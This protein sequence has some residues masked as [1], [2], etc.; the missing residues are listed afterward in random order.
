MKDKHPENKHSISD[1]YSR[2][3]V[4]SQQSSPKGL[5][6][7]RQLPWEKMTIWTL[8]LLLLWTLQEFFSIL[9]FTFV[10][11][12]IANTIVSFFENWSSKR[13]LI[14]AFVYL[15]FLSIILG[16]GTWFGEAVIEMAVPI[17][18]NAGSAIKSLVMESEIDTQNESPSSDLEPSSN[19]PI[20]PRK[21]ET[22]SDKDPSDVKPVLP[23][24]KQEKVSEFQKPEEIPKYVRNVVDKILL[25]SIGPDRTTTF[26]QT[27]YYKTLL[28]EANTLWIEGIPIITGYATLFLQNTFRYTL[29]ILIAL[30]FSFLIVFDIPH[31]RNKLKQFEEG[32]LQEFYKEITPS[33]SNFA[34]VL[35]R[36][37]QAQAMIAIC[38]TIF[39]WGALYFLEIPNRALLT[40][41]VLVFSFVPV[42]GVIIS[43]VPIGFVALLSGGIYKL[44]MIILAILLIHA[45][46]TYILNPNIYG[47]HLKMHPLFVL[48]VLLVAE[49]LFGMWGLILA[50]PVTVYLLEIV[51]LGKTVEELFSA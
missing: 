34:V 40:S 26:Q 33:L 46:E 12:Y 24:E 21:K 9:L 35:G 6:F 15:G 17:A 44:I 22:K 49:H 11:S 3:N 18:N 13:K 30:L 8:F 2:R 51:I 31:L 50:V 14:T 28:N 19:Q 10:F 39:T 48:M 25:R 20:P 37:L 5:Q 36:S 38:N 43:T 42:L 23:P 4:Q 45:F 47:A 7:L 27:S 16:P 29:N 32:K 1:A 41:I